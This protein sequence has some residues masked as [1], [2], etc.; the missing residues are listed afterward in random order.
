MRAGNAAVADIQN[1]RF[2][3]SLG[4]PNHQKKGGGSQGHQGNSYL[5]KQSQ[6]LL[7][8]NLASMLLSDYHV[9][10]PFLV[11]CAMLHSGFQS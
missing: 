10:L 3:L 1:R 8:L 6:L 4:K 9:L 2:L 11:R 7:R 5:K